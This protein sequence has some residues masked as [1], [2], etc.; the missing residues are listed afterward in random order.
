[1]PSSGRDS[2]SLGEGT[3]QGSALPLPAADPELPPPRLPVAA[4]QQ[5]LRDL[6]LPGR[7]LLHGLYHASLRH[8]AG[9]LCC[10]PEPHPPQPL[11]FQNEG[12][13]ENHCRLDHICR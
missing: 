5:A 4:A 11:Q 13:S 2:C 6:D 12:I 7:A 9:P 1:M 3:G 10:H 8:L